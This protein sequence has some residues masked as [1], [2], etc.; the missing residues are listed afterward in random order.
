MTRFSKNAG[1]KYDKY[2]VEQ[3]QQLLA[4]VH[5]NALE[6]VVLLAVLFGLR[7][8]RSAGVTLA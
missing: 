7:R 3:V 8:Q 6:T 4:F 5:G 2:T 1:R